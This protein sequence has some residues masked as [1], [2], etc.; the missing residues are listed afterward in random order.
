MSLTV[1]LGDWNLLPDTPDQVVT[2]HVN[3]V[4]DQPI[5]VIGL[6]FNIQ[7]DDGEEVTLAPKISYI[8][9]L[10]DTIFEFDNTGVVEAKDTSRRWELFVLEHSGAPNTEIPVGLSTLA[11]VTFDTSGYNSG[12]F[13][14][15]LDSQKSGGG[16]AGE[17]AYLDAA[18]DPILM[19][20]TGGFITI[21][22]PS[23][24]L[25]VSLF[26]TAVLLSRHRTLSK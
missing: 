1:N 22:E 20:F 12:K 16:G 7:L 13:S 3:N 15:S 21:P 9:L 19:G 17:T 24:A 14:F 6:Q 5:P 10:L 25:L 23:S 4:T 8:D 18:G 26:L 2:L 11:K